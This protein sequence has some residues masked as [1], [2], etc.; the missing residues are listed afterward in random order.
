MQIASL[1]ISDAIRRGGL[2]MDGPVGTAILAHRPDTADLVFQQGQMGAQGIRRR[3]GQ[4]G[5]LAGSPA[6]MP[7][8]LV[9]ALA[10]AGRMSN[11]GR[12]S[13]A[14]AHDFSVPSNI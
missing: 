8:F 5:A 6:L 4:R 12:F 10:A 3:D 11:D 1:V 13:A 14:A 7:Q 9:I 2:A